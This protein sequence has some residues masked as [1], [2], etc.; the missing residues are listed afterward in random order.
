MSTFKYNRKVFSAAMQRLRNKIGEAA[1]EAVDI[2]VKDAAQTAREIAAWRDPGRH[3]QLYGGTFWSWENTGMARSSIQGY[4][5]GRGALYDLPAMV[6]TS[7]ENGVPLR[8]P[9]TTDSN[10][11]EQRSP[12]PGHV[13]GVIT[14]NVHYGPYLQEWEIDQGREPAT[15]E[16][17]DSHWAAIYVPMLRSSIGGDMNVRT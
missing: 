9:H 7:Y 1:A 4:V 3:E 8:H 14:M 11:T 10:V 16:V 15:I 17:L 12:I 5:I 13:I 2:V 6:T